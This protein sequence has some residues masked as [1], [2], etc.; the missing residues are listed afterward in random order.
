MDHA[1]PLAA[2]SADQLIAQAMEYRRMALAATM[3]ETREALLELAIGFV[4]LAAQRKKEEGRPL[5]NTSSQAR[6]R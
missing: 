1:P 2:R 3:T 5:I 4:A 6:T